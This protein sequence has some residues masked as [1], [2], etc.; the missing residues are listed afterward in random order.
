MLENSNVHPHQFTFIQFAVRYPVI[1]LFL[2]FFQVTTKIRQI[3]K[4]KEFYNRNDLLTLTSYFQSMRFA[5]NCK[6]FSYS[7]LK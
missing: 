6:G 7:V 5:I 2:N 4:E 3:K 1:T